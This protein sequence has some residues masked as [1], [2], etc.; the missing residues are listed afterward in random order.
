[1][2]NTLETQT[3]AKLAKLMQDVQEAIDRNV[4]EMSR[5]EINTALTRFDRYLKIDLKRDLQ[6]AQ[7]NALE[8]SPFDDLISGGL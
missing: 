8:S 1:M 3:K 5:G 4:S 6:Q 2:S 7:D